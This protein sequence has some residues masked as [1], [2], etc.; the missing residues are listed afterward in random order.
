MLV[1]FIAQ[2]IFDIK[3]EIFDFIVKTLNVRGL[4]NYVKRKKYL[5]GS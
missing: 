3:D 5:T 2:N 1:Y 4:R